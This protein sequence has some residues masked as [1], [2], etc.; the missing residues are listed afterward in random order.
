MQPVD[1]INEIPCLTER[2]LEVLRYVACGNSNKQIARKLGISQRTVCFH[3]TNCFI[4]MEA[5]NRTEAIVKAAHYGLI[6]IVQ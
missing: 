2:E 6:D 1:N 3:M 5:T 4:K